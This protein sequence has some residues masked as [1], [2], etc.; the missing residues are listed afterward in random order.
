MGVPHLSM[1]NQECRGHVSG[2]MTSTRTNFGHEM[3]LL[4]TPL[5]GIAQNTSR[6][7]ASRWRAG[8]MTSTC[9]W[10]LE[11]NLTEIWPGLK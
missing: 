2:M 1:E 4:R 7:L 8:T 6:T 5:R 11:V 9:Q 3:L 10:E